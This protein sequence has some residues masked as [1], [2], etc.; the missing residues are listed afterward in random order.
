VPSCNPLTQVRLTDGAVACGSSD[1]LSPDRACYLANGVGICAVAGDAAATQGTVAGPFVNACAP[2]FGTQFTDQLP[3]GVCAAFCAPAPTSA[4]SAQNAGG[5]P[6][7]GFTCNEAGAPTAECRFLSPA[8]SPTAPPSLGACFD[9]ADFSVAPG[10]PYRSC[11]VLDH[12][13][14]DADGLL[15]DEQYGCVPLN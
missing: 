3:G 2:G 13:D 15:D 11:T 4:T 12:T 7:S 5:E 6:A 1:P 9:F 14:A 8:F 10:V